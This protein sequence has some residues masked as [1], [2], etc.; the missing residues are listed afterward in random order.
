MFS[1]KLLPGVFA[2]V[3]LGASP[4]IADGDFY[5]DLADEELYQ[6]PAKDNGVYVLL[7]AGIGDAKEIKKHPFF[8]KVNWDDVYNRKLKPPKPI[9]KMIKNPNYVP[10][11][12]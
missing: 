9:N 3:V 1:K 4:C 5:D 8:S 6:E 2:A 7:G 11:I 12:S 10:N